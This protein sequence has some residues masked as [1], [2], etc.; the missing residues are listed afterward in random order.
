MALVGVV[1]RGGRSKARERCALREP[2]LSALIHVCG[3]R[4]SAVCSVQRKCVR[5]V[6]STTWVVG[7][8]IQ[9]PFWALGLLGPLPCAWCWCVA[10]ARRPGAL[11]APTRHA[12]ISPASTSSSSSLAPGWPC[13]RS[14]WPRWLL[15]DSC[16][17]R[18]RCV[19][20]LACLCT[21]C[22]MSIWPLPN[23]KLQFL[24]C[25]LGGL[26]HAFSTPN[27]ERTRQRQA[28]TA[29][30][31]ATPPTPLGP[32]QRDNGITT[33]GCCPALP[34]PHTP[35]LIYAA[36]RAASDKRRDR[37]RARASHFFSAAHTGRSFTVTVP[38]SQAAASDPRSISPTP[39]P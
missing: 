25:P 24:L 11:A 35:H 17:L 4:T 32:S 6:L 7:C 39:E 38:L 9:L 37:R 27:E 10:W 29:A 8:M 15:S 31:A 20:G 2:A 3:V 28:A 12:Q 16:V 19:A 26:S 36:Q 23:C 13:W 5:S 1:W 21:A 22:L 18:A 34:R 30:A 14:R 33:T